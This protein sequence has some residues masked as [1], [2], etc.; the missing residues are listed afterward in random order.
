ITSRRHLNWCA[1]VNNWCAPVVKPCRQ[2]LLPAGC[3]RLDVPGASRS[4][5]SRHRA[6]PGT[7][8]GCL[9]PV[10]ARGPVMALGWIRPR[11]RTR[12]RSCNRRATRVKVTRRGAVSD[13]VA[14]WTGWHANALRQALRMTNEEF[15]EH[16]DVSVRTVV[17]WRTRPEIVPRQGMQQILD[18]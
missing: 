3:N 6:G 5:A 13:L 18:V 14:T 10:L 11:L 15:A 9:V 7:H 12:Q 8:A 16:L 17:Y 1:P 4:A 2:P